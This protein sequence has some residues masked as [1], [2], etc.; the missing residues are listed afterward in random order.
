MD[1]QTR[2][3]SCGALVRDIDGPTHSY[4]DSSPGCWELYCEV[5]ARAYS[6]EYRDPHIL[7]VAV[8]AFA[9]QHPGKP[10]RRAIQSVNGHLVSLYLFY[11]KKTVSKQASSAVKHLVED[12]NTVTGFTW[13]EPPSFK[14][15]LTV[16]DVLRAKSA[17]EHKKLVNDWGESVWNVWKVKHLKTVEL[18]VTKLLK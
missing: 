13:L 11:E 4:M 5:L 10:E 14:D 17:S 9:C 15:S 18:H 16:A 6:P 7:Q 3:F 2:C 12:E 1:R 8:D